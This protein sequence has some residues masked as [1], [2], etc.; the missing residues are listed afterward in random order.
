MMLMRVM[1]RSIP[2]SQKKTSERTV[3]LPQTFAEAAERVRLTPT[4]L[5]AIRN[6]ATAWRLTGDDAATLVGVSPSTWDRINA[7]AW[8]QTL[9]QDQL[10][11]ISALVGIFKG[12]HLLFADDMADRWPR[13]GNSGPLFQNLSP[14]EAMQQGGIPLMLDV[15]QHIDALRGGL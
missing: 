15:R 1:P 3:S 8:K 5:K 4:A 7:G 9:S 6:L 2:K 14:V 11:R 12:L 13:L 10:T